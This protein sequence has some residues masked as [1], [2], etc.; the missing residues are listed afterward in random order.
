MINKGLTFAGSC[1]HSG[2]SVLAGD[3]LRVA[4]WQPRAACAT[5][6]GAHACAR[7]ACTR[8]AQTS[9]ATGGPGSAICLPLI[10]RNATS[11]PPAAILGERERQTDRQMKVAPTSRDLF[12]LEHGKR[13]D[14]FFFS[15]WPNG[16]FRFL[17]H[18]CITFN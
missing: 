14:F 11:P 3:Q 2:P 1:R 9:A 16:V 15:A 7:A 13:Y 17:Q 12:Q 4:P 6:A 5:A 10:R 18:D 8:T